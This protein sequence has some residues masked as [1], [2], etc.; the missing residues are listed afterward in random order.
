MAPEKIAC[1]SAGPAL[2]VAVLS[3]TFGPSAWLKMPSWTPTSAVAWVR[4]GKYPRVRVTFSAVAG[5][6][7]CWLEAAALLEDDALLEDLVLLE[8]AARAE[9]TARTATARNP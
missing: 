9:A 2:N 4:F 7:V 1:T 8:Q 6:A 3:V 5:A